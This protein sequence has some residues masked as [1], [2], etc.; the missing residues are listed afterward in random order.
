MFD[1]SKCC[2][3]SYVNNMIIDHSEMCFFLPWRELGN[4]VCIYHRFHNDTVHLFIQQ[5]IYLL[6]I[7]TKNN[8]HSFTQSCMSLRGLNNIQSALS[9]DNLPH[10]DGNSGDVQN[11]C[12][13][14]AN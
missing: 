13:P 3:H 5:D 2:I 7:Q 14:N 10:I 4:S 1:F 12:H 8:G 9:A 6:L 11:V